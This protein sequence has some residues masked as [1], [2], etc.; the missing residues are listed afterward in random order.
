[1]STSNVTPDAPP[2]QTPL[3]KAADDVIRCLD[4]AHV[5]SEG[6]GIERYE[7]SVELLA[8]SIGRLFHEATKARA[9]RGQPTARS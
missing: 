8:K 1:V 3:D 2:N 5:A 6:A 4:G 7:E 9:A